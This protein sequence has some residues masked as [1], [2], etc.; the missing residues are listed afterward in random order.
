M[1]LFRYLC[2]VKGKNK[3]GM[4][5]D[6]AAVQNK[7]EMGSSERKCS[8]A[9]S[10]AFGF[11]ET[12]RERRK[13]IGMTQEELADKVGCKRTYIN[14]IEMGKTDLQLSSFLRISEALGLVLYLDEKLA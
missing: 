14:R 12:L 8:E 11:S 5:R 6:L 7:N 10:R 3:N 4:K 9:K 1:K 13:S 2:R